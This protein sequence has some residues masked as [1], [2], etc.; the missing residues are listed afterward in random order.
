LNS[1]E[2]KK[3]LSDL[4]IPFLQVTSKANNRNQ[5][6]QRPDLGRKIEDISL[7]VLQNHCSGFDIALII[8]DGLSA[9]GVN[10]HVVGILKI[11][12]PLLKELKYS[13]APV[14][15]VSQAR[16]AIGDEIGDLLGA[17]LSIVFIGE[18]PGLS[19]SDSLGVY[20]TYHPLPGLTDDKRNCISNIHSEGMDYHSA[21]QK[22]IYLIKESFRLQLSGV[23]LKESSDLL[24]I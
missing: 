10:N 17:K 13:I 16:V 9:V 4:Q 19:V 12:I 23:L 5:Y 20:L 3:G 24:E 7:A 18:R 14:T 8:A 15:I 21:V 1:T 11:L 6:L 2:I 22:L